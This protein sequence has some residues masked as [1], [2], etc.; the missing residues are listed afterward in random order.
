MAFVGALRN[1]E[2]K[3]LNKIDIVCQ[4]VGVAASIVIAYLLGNY[5]AILISNL[6][7][8]LFRIW[9]SYA[10]FPNS[11]RRWRFSRERVAEMWQFRVSSPVRRS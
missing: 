2:V 5:W 10:W 3:R 4:C 1:R 7:L 9:L 11:G 6:F 8:Q